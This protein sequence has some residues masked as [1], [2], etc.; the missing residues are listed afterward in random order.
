MSD[1]LQHSLLLQLFERHL[2]FRAKCKRNRLG[3]DKFRCR[4]RFQ[5]QLCLHGTYWPRPFSKTASC[6]SKTCCSVLLL[7]WNT[8]FQSTLIL[9]SQTQLMIGSWFVTATR[10]S[11]RCLSPWCCTSAR[12]ICRSGSFLSEYIVRLTGVPL[13]FFLGNLCFQVS[14]P[15]RFFP[16]LVSISILTGTWCITIIVAHVSLLA[17]TGVLVWKVPK[18]SSSS[19][20]SPETGELEE[21]DF[22][23]AHWLVMTLFVAF[24]LLALACRHVMVLATA[25]TLACACACACFNFGACGESWRFNDIGRWSD[26][27][28]LLSTTL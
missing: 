9:L 22:A 7:M 24:L 28:Q 26:S 25:I 13:S 14:L 17:S 2:H 11:R 23:A 19:F 27:T 15:V 18:V 4:T 21:L 1:L 10:S 6:L 8:P 3:H 5:V 12:Q 16:E 20:S